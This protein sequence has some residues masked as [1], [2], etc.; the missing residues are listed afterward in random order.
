MFGGCFVV[1]VVQGSNGE[2]D[3]CAAGERNSKAFVVR[4]IGLPSRG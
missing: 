4:I 1:G 3:S 2:E